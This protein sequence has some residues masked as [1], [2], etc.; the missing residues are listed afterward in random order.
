M[1]KHYN[2]ILDCVRPTVITFRTVFYSS[3]FTKIY[4]NRCRND[5]ILLLIERDHYYVSIS[6]KRQ[7]CLKKSFRYSHVQRIKLFQDIY[8]K[9]LPIIKSNKCFINTLKKLSSFYRT[10]TFV[11]CCNFDVLA[12]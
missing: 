7:I 12:E 2:I 3:I 5:E 8:N 4:F 10:L 11:I 9:Y 6:T 1:I